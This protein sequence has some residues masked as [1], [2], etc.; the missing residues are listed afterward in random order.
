MN[1]NIGNYSGPRFTSSTLCR[2][3]LSCAR[4][5]QR[6]GAV[7]ATEEEVESAPCRVDLSLHTAICLRIYRHKS[8]KH[9]QIHIRVHVHIHLD[10]RLDMYIQVWLFAQ[11]GGPSCRCP[12]NKSPTV[13]SPYLK[14]QT[15]RKLPDVLTMNSIPSEACR[16]QV[17]PDASSFWGRL[18]CLGLYVYHYLY[19]HI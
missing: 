3:G 18:W 5:L 9:I 17:P 14:P 16:T 15:F 1:H 6:H 12:Y 19:I 13:F 11:L 4:F 8:F 2:L 7:K 10:I